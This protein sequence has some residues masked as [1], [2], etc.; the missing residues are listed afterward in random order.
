MENQ[1]LIPPLNPQPKTLLLTGGSQGIGRATVELFLERGWRVAFVARN[2]DGVQQTVR[3]LIAAGFAPDSICGEVLDVGDLDAVE[4]LPERLGMLAGGLDALVLNAFYQKIK[5]AHELTR[6]EWDN[7]WRINCLSPTL[8]IKACMPLLKSSAGSI[9]Y[10]GSVMDERAEPGYA[11]YGAGK[12][13]MKSFIRHAACDFGPLGVRINGVSPGAVRTEALER[14]IHAAGPEG[15]EIFR[16]LKQRIPMDNR[17]C[18][19]REVAETIWFAAT[20]PRHFHGRD[21]RIDGG[22][23]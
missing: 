4:A 16:E 5:P 23:F 15:N 2:P 10:V 1:R 3:E 13:F 18:E 14:A 12:A 17:V 11:A 6:E 22:L 8:L 21:L 20:G 7:H 19:P 9:V